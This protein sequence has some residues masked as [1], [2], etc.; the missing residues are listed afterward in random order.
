MEMFYVCT[1]QYGSHK[2][3]VATV[4]EKIYFILFWFNQFKFK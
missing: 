3:H 4:I 2:P 1:V